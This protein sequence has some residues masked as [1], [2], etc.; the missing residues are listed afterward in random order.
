MQN[1]NAPNILVF[2]ITRR[3]GPNSS[4]AKTEAVRN[5]NSCCGRRRNRSPSKISERRTSNETTE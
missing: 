4:N 3:I 5:A 1:D 2:G